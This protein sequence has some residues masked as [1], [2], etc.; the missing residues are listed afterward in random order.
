MRISEIIQK[1]VSVMILAVISASLMGCD[2]KPYLGPEA[3]SI[4][5]D[6]SA[7]VFPAEG[8]TAVFKVTDRKGGEY[9]IYETW[10]YYSDRDYW[11]PEGTENYFGEIENITEEPTKWVRRLDIDPADGTLTVALHE[12]DSIHGMSLFIRIVRLPTEKWQDVDG[13]CYF[14]IFQLGKDYKPDK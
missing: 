2:D 6:H 8:G 1:C 5:Y 12:N 13:E 11:N 3:D 7:Y 9:H 4:Y 10:L 14:N